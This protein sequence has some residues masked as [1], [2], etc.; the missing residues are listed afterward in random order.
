[1]MA[2]AL[3][4][5][6]D[7]GRFRSSTECQ[8]R[9]KDKSS[10]DIQPSLRACCFWEQHH[11]TSQFTRGQPLVGNEWDVFTEEWAVLTEISCRPYEVRV[12]VSCTKKINSTYVAL[13]GVPRTRNTCEY[14]AVMCCTGCTRGRHRAAIAVPRHRFRARVCV[15]FCVSSYLLSVSRTVWRRCSG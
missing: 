12:R 10:P 2:G 4:Y 1:M 6:V 9:Q 14:L 15:V 3:Q 7:G 13:M 5:H 8:T 11:A